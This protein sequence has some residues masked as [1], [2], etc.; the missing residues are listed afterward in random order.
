M[1]SLML[2]FAL[3]LICGI[4]LDASQLPWKLTD[5]E[6]TPQ[7]WEAPNPEVGV[8]AVWIAGPPYKG[9]PTRA[10]AY[11]GIP[12]S[13]RNTPGMVLIHG[14]GGTAFAE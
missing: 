9:K 11:Y 10:F 12:S 5:L 4:L 7:S 8:K 14:G 1:S 6:K 2:R 13:N 3:L